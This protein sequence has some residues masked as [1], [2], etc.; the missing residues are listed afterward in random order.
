MKICRSS[1]A[2]Y[3]TFD[4]RFWHKADMG[5]LFCVGKGEGRDRHLAH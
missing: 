2:Y 5:L 3:G 4:V 1:D